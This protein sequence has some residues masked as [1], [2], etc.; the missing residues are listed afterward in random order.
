M[1]WLYVVIAV[2]SIYAAFRSYQGGS[3][4]ERSNLDDVQTNRVSGSNTIQYICG[5]VKTKELN[6]FWYG[7][8]ETKPLK[9]KIKGLFGSSKE[10]VGEKIFLG[11]A[12]LIAYGVIDSLKEIYFGD[13]LAWEGDL[14]SGDFTIDKPE[15]FGNDQGVKNGVK[16]DFTFYSGTSDQAV[17][18]YLQSQLGDVPAYRHVSYLVAKKPYIG[19]SASVRPMSLVLSRYPNPLNQTNHVI[20]EGANPIYVLYEMYQNGLFGK[21]YPVQRIEQ[22]SFLTAAQSVFDEGRGVSFAFSQTGSLKKVREQIQQHVNCAFYTDLTTGRLNVNLIREDYDPEALPSFDDSTIVDIQNFKR[23]T[24]SNVVT[25]VRVKYINNDENYKERIAV[26]SDHGARLMLGYHRSR[27]ISY[28]GYRRTEIAEQIASR[29]RDT[30][31]K[32]PAKGKMIANRTAASL[33]RGDPFKISF[34]PLGIDNLVCRVESK[35]IGTLADGKVTIAFTQDQFSL[36]DRVYTQSPNSDWVEIIN[37][38]QPV[39]TYSIFE[40]P[41]LIARGVGLH[42]L[43]VLAAAPT[44]DANFFN[45]VSDD[46]SGEELTPQLPFSEPY[47]LSANISESDASITITGLPEVEASTTAGVRQ[48]DNLALIETAS[49]GEIIAFTGFSTNSGETTLTGVQRGLL[50]TIPQAINAGALVWVLEDGL[51]LADDF[52]GGSGN[53]T[54]NLNTVTYRGELTGAPD[55]IHALEGRANLPL[56]PA[57]LEFNGASFPASISGELTVDFNTRDRINQQEVQLQSDASDPIEGGATT[58]LEI[59]GDGGTLKRTESGLIGDTFTYLTADEQADNGGSVNSSLRVVAYSE[60]SGS[61]SY[62]KWDHSF[63]RV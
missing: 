61:E 32:Q 40:L 9:K 58:T 17:D 31:S 21:G 42:Q 16:G 49:G 15:L 5:T 39:V 24:M 63:I 37:E 3:D 18:P 48:G 52:F 34:S 2:I 1:F 38:P 30:L 4:F 27:E 44:Q 22:S 45:L 28:Y 53:V 51:T 23:G 33:N 12:K 56:P 50:D 11:E 55:V 6:S 35:N 26:A 41:H 36:G 29:E 62:Q 13:H 43:V 59:Y 10:T 20:Q 14:S 8:F 19:N 46:G 60:R 47:P 7:D 54:L 25:E 57:G